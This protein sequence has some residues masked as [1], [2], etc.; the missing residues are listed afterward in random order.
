MRTMF[1]SLGRNPDSGWSTWTSSVVTEHQRQRNT[2]R[3]Q[4]ETKRKKKCKDKNSLTCVPVR[5]SLIHIQLHHQIIVSGQIWCCHLF[6]FCSY[7]LASVPTWRQWISKQI[8]VLR[9]DASMVSCDCAPAQIKT[10]SATKALLGCWLTH[11]SSLRLQPS[12]S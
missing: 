2:H 6:R 4:S 12:S 7:L 1:L 9:I 10:S 3:C 5:V 11:V 8:D